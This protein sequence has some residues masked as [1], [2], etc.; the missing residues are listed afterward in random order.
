M[1]RPLALAAALAFIGFI[2]TATIIANRGEGDQWWGFIHRIP[3]GDKLGHLG[4]IGTLA[5]LCNLAF[6]KGKPAGFPHL[7][8][9]TT[10][11]L[12]ILLSAEEI[13]QAFIPTRTCDFF[14][15]LADVS[16]LALGQYCAALFREWGSTRRPGYHT[17]S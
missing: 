10:W 5:L 14:D 2:I 4:L 13:A 8:T 12:L 9:R 6:T 3:Y 16:G 7:V 17:T 15:W 11:V 1:K